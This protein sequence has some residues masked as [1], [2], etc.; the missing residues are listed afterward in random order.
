M[1]AAAYVLDL[2][3]PF[4]RSWAYLLPLCAIQAGA[5]LAAGAESVP[6]GRARSALLASALP[7]ALGAALALGT[8]HAG[9][10]GDLDA[11]QSDND[12]VG[13]LKRDLRPGQALVLD[14]YTVEV[15]A[16]YY[17]R[18]FGYK[19]PR[20]PRRHA[21]TRAL[22]IVPRPGGVERVRAAAAERGW[23]V[24]PSPPPRLVR[25]LD[26]IEAWDARLR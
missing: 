13:E 7:I 26:Y 8:L 16:S 2:A 4:P 18:R 24:S 21:A 11:P 20:L 23:Q 3:A 6:R 14:R 22:V 10:R 5:G 19:P 15:P 1:A 25:R 17:F 12:I 9:D